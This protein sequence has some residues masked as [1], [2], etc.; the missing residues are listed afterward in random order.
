MK[1]SK[2]GIFVAIVFILL[3]T[4]TASGCVYMNVQTPLDKNFDETDLGSK[5]GK[6]EATMIMGLIA[7][8]D[9]GTK[10]AAENGGIKII[11]HADR[12]LYVVCFGLYTKIT[13]VV[14]GD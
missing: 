10:A 8:G 5:I 11:K 14:Y 6:S 2:K 12:E 13:T 9:A 4:L 3:L 7:W 1:K